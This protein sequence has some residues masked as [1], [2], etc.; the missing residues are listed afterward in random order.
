MN[1]DHYR[2]NDPKRFLVSIF[3]CRASIA[4]GKAK[5]KKKDC[6]FHR[7]NIV[8]NNFPFDNLDPADFGIRLSNPIREV[9]E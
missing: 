2:C 1:D 5:C 9:K 7:R 4:K 8:Y 6:G 3:I